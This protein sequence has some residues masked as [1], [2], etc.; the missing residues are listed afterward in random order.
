MNETSIVPARS[1]ETEHQVLPTFGRLP[2]RHSVIGV[3]SILFICFTIAWPTPSRGA[4]DRPAQFM[5]KVSKQLVT[6]SRSGSPHILAG[7]I[8]S[9]ADVPDIG[10]YSL[11]SYMK[12]LPKHRRTSYYDGV[13]RFMARYFM[14]QAK[15]Y[16]VAKIDIFSPS[17]RADWGHKVDSK[18]TLTNGDTYSLRW[19]VVQRGSGFKV[20]DVSILGFWMTPFQR[21]LFEGYIE[22]KGGNVNALLAALGG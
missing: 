4:T 17:S 7:V 12:R 13:A 19:L 15:S 21:K 14:A 11:G 18:I 9:Y 20:R 10:L 8:R 2:R 3:I 16:P 1:H 5:R 22:E 6:A